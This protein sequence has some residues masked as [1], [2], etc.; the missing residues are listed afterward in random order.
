[1]KLSQK[2]FL[3]VFKNE[4]FSTYAILY[5]VAVVVGVAGFYLGWWAHLF[6]G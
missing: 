5:T 3:K 2:A 4:K 1:M 6:G